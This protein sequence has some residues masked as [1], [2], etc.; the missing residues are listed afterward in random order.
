M[1]MYKRLNEGSDIPNVDITVDIDSGGKLDIPGPEEMTEP[2]AEELEEAI[3]TQVDEV[4][5]E[6]E[7]LQQTEMSLLRTAK[8]IRSSGTFHASLRKFIVEEDEAI[9]P[10]IEDTVDYDEAGEHINETEIEKVEE[11]IADSTDAPIEV[12]VEATVALRGISKAL[13]VIRRRMAASQSRLKAMYKRSY[14]RMSK[15]DKVKTW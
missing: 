2:A 1:S 15:M 4:V 3:D 9:V 14:A 7:E 8:A 13:V 11:E 5:E 6:N 10:V 12:D